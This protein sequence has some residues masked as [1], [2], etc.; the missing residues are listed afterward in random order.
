[1]NKAQLIEELAG[2]FAGNRKH[3][4]HALE[5][6]LD[7]V[8]RS[9]AAGERVGITGFGVFERAE[10]AARTARNPRTGEKVRVKKTAVPRFKPGQGFKDVVANPKARR[11]PAGAVAAVEATVPPPRS[12]AAAT[13]K[14]ATTKAATTKA[15]SRAAGKTTVAKVP[16]SRKPATK[17]AGPAP[18]RKAATKAPA[19]RTRATT[20]S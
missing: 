15:P 20:T 13:T 4:A 19:T 9:V 18:A 17:T 6:V 7:V 2:R 3:A 8:T 1:M 11:K 14:A 12:G 16:A 5:A 10:R